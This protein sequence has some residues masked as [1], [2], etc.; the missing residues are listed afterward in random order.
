MTELSLR[1]LCCSFYLNTQI[2]LYMLC[3]HEN[4]EISMNKIPWMT[5]FFV[6]LLPISYE[7]R[8]S[9]LSFKFCILF[10]LV[11]IDFCVDKTF[12]TFKVKSFFKNNVQGRATSIPFLCTY[13]FYLIA[14]S[15]HF[16]SG[17]SFFHFISLGPSLS[18][19][20]QEASLDI[21]ILIHSLT[22][23]L[24]FCSFGFVS[25][26]P[27]WVVYLFSCFHFYQF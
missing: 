2:C 4:A 22:L 21:C 14:I 10:F 6:W 3:K 12:T 19:F 20:F 24:E 1:F 9:V 26:F 25:F 15:N 5:L 13:Y 18:I 8:F 27:F 23:F 17:F 11:E 7:I 16:Y